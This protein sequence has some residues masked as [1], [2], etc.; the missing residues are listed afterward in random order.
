VKNTKETNHIEFEVQHLSSHYM[1]TYDTQNPRGKKFYDINFVDITC[2][3]FNGSTW[4]LESS[5]L[6]GPVYLIKTQ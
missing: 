2:N 4:N 3:F 5:G 1:R 6:F